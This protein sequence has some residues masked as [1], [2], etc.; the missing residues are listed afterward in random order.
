MTPIT[1]HAFVAFLIVRYATASS[2]SPI[3]INIFSNKVVLF[4]ICLNI[5][6]FSNVY[7]KFI[8]KIETIISTGVDFSSYTI[9]KKAVCALPAYN[10]NDMTMAVNS[11]I[12]KFFEISPIVIPKGV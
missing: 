3:P 1:Y 12:P 9:F 6:I 2:V 4:E 7:L 11:F 8:T 5:I 10:P